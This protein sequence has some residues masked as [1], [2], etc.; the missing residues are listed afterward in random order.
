MLSHLRVVVT[1]DRGT[2]ESQVKVFDDHEYR[3]ALAADEVPNP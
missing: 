1:D 3:N 2:H